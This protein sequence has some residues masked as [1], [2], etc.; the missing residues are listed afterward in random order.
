MDKLI[1]EEIQRMTLL[2]KYDNSKTL[3]EQSQLD[4]VIY[5]TKTGKILQPQNQTQTTTNTPTNQQTNTTQTTTTEKKQTT[6]KPTGTSTPNTKE[7][8]IGVT[9]QYDYPNDKKYV[10]GVKD[11]KWFG[12]NLTNGKEFDLSTFTTAID[13]LS[14]KF[15]NALKQGTPS[16]PL[17]LNNIDGV[18]SFQDWLD[19]NVKGWASG[20][21]DGIINKG[22]NGGGYGN[23]GARTQK[24]WNTYKDKYLQQNSPEELKPI[25]AQTLPVQTPQTPTQPTAASADNSPAEGD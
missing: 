24:A 9:Y 12:K 5:D 25:Q 14:K 1:S 19:V 11:G 7:S 3:S 4:E 23:F 10:Y 18:K 20:Y 15:P 8:S 13:N 16:L 6:L 22:Q 21:K 2:S 17:Q